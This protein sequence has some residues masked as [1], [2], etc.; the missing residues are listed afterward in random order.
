[1]GDG[2]LAHF[3]AAND[4]LTYAKDCL[5]SVYEINTEIDNW[6]AERSLQGKSKIVVNS[7]S[8]TGDIVFG[9]AGGAGRLEYTIIGTP[10]N[11]TAKLEKYNKEIGATS[12]TTQLTLDKALEYGFS[13][14]VSRKFKT[15]EISGVSGEQEIAVLI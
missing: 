11:L 15:N 5:N 13:H 8:S 12:V 14:Q 10:V 4:S 6:N 9:A 1:M 3:G 2:I 7:A